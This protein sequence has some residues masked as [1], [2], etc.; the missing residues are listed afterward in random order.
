MIKIQKYLLV[1]ETIENEIINIGIKFDYAVYDE[2]H[3]I[4][5]YNDGNIYENL[6]K[7]ID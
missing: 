3:N 4:N 1:Y 7:L 2:I 6:I 5:N